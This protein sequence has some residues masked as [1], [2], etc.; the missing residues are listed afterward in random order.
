[1][2]KRLKLF[3]KSTLT[4]LTLAGIA[5]SMLFVC[6]DLLALGLGNLDVQSNLNEPLRGEIELLTSSVDD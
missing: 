1:M 2:A 6:A 4:H 3:E 5:M